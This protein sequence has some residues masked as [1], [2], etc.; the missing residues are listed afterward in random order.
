ML[1]PQLQR[2]AG[3]PEH[4]QGRKPPLMLAIYRSYRLVCL[5][6]LALFAKGKYILYCHSQRILEREVRFTGPVGI[7]SHTGDSSR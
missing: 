4:A 5:L 6:D 2:I 3:R 7:D 1:Q